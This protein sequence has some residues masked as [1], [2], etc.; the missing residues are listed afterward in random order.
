MKILKN[1]SLWSRGAGALVIGSLLVPVAAGCGAPAPQQ[2]APG[3]PAASNNGG[4]STRQKLTLLAGAAALYYVYNN[5]KKQNQAR[6][7]N[8]NVQYY[9]SKSTGRVYYRDPKNPRNVIWVTPPP[10]QQQPIQVPES[11]AMAYRQFQGYNNAG[12]GQTLRDVFPVQ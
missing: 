11:D 5:Y 6:L 8:Q 4:M 10:A 2:N 1:S 7:A 3:A 9:L 12:S